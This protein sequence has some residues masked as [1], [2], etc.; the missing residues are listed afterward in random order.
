[1]LIKRFYNNKIYIAI[2]IVTLIILSIIKLTN[3]ESNTIIALVDKRNVNPKF[4]DKTGSLEFLLL[5]TDDKSSRKLKTVKYPSKHFIS[6]LYPKHKPIIKSKRK[7]QWFLADNALGSRKKSGHQ[8]V[9]TEI[10]YQ[11]NALETSNR[12]SNTGKYQGKYFHEAAFIEVDSSGRKLNFDKNG[13]YIDIASLSPGQYFDANSGLL[14]A[15]RQID[16]QVFAYQEAYYEEKPDSKKLQENNRVVLLSSKNG[17]RRKIRA[18]FP[19]SFTIMM[20]N[21]HS[22]GCPTALSDDHSKLCFLG[23]PTLEDSNGNPYPIYLYT[24]TLKE[25]LKLFNFTIPNP[26]MIDIDKAYTTEVMELPIERNSSVFANPINSMQFKTGNN[27]ILAINIC[28]NGNETEKI[29]KQPESPVILV[30][31]LNKRKIIKKI[32]LSVKSFRWSPSGEKMGILDNK[33]K[34]YCWNYD[35]EEL[36]FVFENK[37]LYDFVWVE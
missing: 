35:T 24:L 26:L 32:N 37:D 7:N 10:A 25:D 30:I 31:D 34:I 3:K 17:K 13:L 1:M 5:N 12:I 29:K 14:M 18:G 6:S 19:P 22:N 4:K 33:G 23:S 15:F 16:G 20:E 36:T 21:T 9:I 2:L 28:W 27:N 11:N 8:W